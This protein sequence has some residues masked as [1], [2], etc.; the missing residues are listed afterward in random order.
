M[1]DETEILRVRCP[2]CNKKYKVDP[3][4]K[5]RCKE[6]EAVVEVDEKGNATLASEKK[7]KDRSE[8]RPKHEEAEPEDRGSQSSR[9]DQA[10]TKT[11]RAE[12]KPSE[13]KSPE[14]GKQKGV[15]KRLVAAAQTDEDEGLD[16][17]SDSKRSSTSRFAKTSSEVRDK[18]STRSQPSKRRKS[19]SDSQLGER[20]GSSRR[21][22]AA[23]GG[24]GKKPMGLY[25]GVGGGAALLVV[26]V[27]AF[28]MGG[29]GGSEKA[30][31][32]KKEE[33]KKQGLVAEWA[34][35]VEG[36]IAF[37][38]QQ[39]SGS[40][41]LHN[42][43]EKEIAFTYQPQVQFRIL[44]EEPIG[45]ES[46]GTLDP[47]V[48]PKPPQTFK[49]FAGGE[50]Q[51]FEKI[52]ADALGLDDSLYQRVTIAVW[53]EFAPQSGSEWEK[54]VTS[55]EVEVSYRRPEPGEL[56]EYVANFDTVPG[57]DEKKR[58]L[59]MAGRHGDHSFNETLFKKALA[60]KAPSVKLVAA[61][62]CALRK[63]EGTEEILRGW[64]DNPTMKANW[65]K[66]P[67]DKAELDR[68]LALY[69]RK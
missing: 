51:G 27:L 4:K 48:P 68:C 6:C 64:L 16:R 15:S 69:E 46:M 63:I 44:K 28:A 60:D 13:T 55:N 8:R 49:F 31:Q 7:A 22:R 66:H 39:I 29:G 61:R 23:R 25:L 14:S 43:T 33:L 2:A 35:E 40:W 62:Y 30:A 58:M 67:E 53:V 10:R 41:T 65:E 12:K 37:H 19:L 42:Y 34:L 50:L 52:A 1:S 59:H 54:T 24:P 5:F 11:G 3:P 9:K 17:K 38:E 47:L 32:A 26:V 56:R 20:A 36:E 18:G 57:H 21:G 45:H